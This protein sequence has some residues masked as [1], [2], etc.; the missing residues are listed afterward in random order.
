MEDYTT[1][2][3][4]LQENVKCENLK[5]LLVLY[6]FLLQIN[7][8]ISFL[9]DSRCANHLKW[10]EIAVKIC[11]HPH[12]PYEMKRQAQDALHHRPFH[13]AFYE[14]RQNITT[15]LWSI[16][17]KMIIFTVSLANGSYKVV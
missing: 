17:D 6:Y 16:D 7:Q 13:T 11:D 2:D 3:E 10:I 8:E 1:D 4:I 12:V 9:V 5:D 15:Q 14:L